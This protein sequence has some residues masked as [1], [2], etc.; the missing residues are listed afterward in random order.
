M[1]IA[2]ARVRSLFEAALE[3]PAADRA[4]FLVRECG[5]DGALLAEVE[6]MLASD[7]STTPF[8]AVLDGPAP[9]VHAGGARGPRTG[10]R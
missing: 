10:R 7:A 2:F 5:G 3:Q 1:T 6:A 9:L 4:A 8:A